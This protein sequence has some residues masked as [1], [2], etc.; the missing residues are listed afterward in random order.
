MGYLGFI[1]LGL[2]GFRDRW[3]FGTVGSG[4]LVALGIEMQKFSRFEK[5]YLL[6]THTGRVLGEKMPR[7]PSQLQGP[8]VD[9][10]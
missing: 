4:V 7:S 9:F 3:F 1:F 6:D 8:D 2:F 10:M 5:A